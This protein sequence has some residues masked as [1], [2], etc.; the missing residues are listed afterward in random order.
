[1]LRYA[2]AIALLFCCSINPAQAAET[3]LLRERAV[4][5]L[6]D[7]SVQ[8]AQTGKAVFA[9]TIAPDADMANSW[10]AAHLLQQEI[11]F[12]AMGTDRYGRALIIS[13]LQEK[14][15]RDG[16][17]LIY[18]SAGDIPASWRAAEA[19][20]RAAKRGVWGDPA[21][22]LLLTPETALKTMA[23]FHIVEGTIT[24]IY[25][26]K[27]ATYLNFGEDWHS[28]FS[29]TI[30]AKQRRSMKA[31]LADLKAGDRVCVR[32]SIVE[33]NGPMIR[34]NHPDNLERL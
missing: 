10:L 17:I 3:K 13:E 23:G 6:P 5:V 31:F 29:I 12:A 34:L 9:S 32:G 1:M 22:A 21:L 7:G 8:L 24:R 28:D 25:E 19:S 27:S 30:A 33:E 15:L 18:A 2:A 26:G 14:M 16:V 20:A 4:A 11:S